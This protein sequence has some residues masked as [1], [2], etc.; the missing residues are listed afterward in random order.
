MLPRLSPPV[1]MLAGA[2]AT[3]LA[4]GIRPVSPLEW[5]SG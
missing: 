2:E 4:V 5:I 3:N 1:G